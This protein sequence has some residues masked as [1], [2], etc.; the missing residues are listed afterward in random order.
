M[1][2]AYISATQF[3]VE[4]DLTAEFLPGRRIKADCGGD[5]YKYS[6]VTSRSYSNPYTTVTIAEGELTSNLIDVLYGI[7]N[8]G[9]EGSFP[10][11]TH[12]SSE[13]QGGVISFDDLADND[14][15]FLQLIDT[16]SSY[17]SN[18]VLETTGSGIVFSDKLDN[19]LQLTDTPTTYSG[20]EGKYII[21]TTSGLEFT[22]ISGGSGSSDVESFLDLNDTPTTY[23]GTEGQVATS[24]GSGIVFSN[25]DVTNVPLVTG[26]QGIK[27]EY[28]SDNEVYFNPG[29][30][31]LKDSNYDT[32]VLD[33]RISIQNTGLE[34]S[35]WYFIYVEEPGVGNLLS[36]ENFTFSSIVPTLDYVNQG[37][38]NGFKRCVG[39]VVTDSGSDIIRFEQN[40][41]DYWFVPK[42][43]DFSWALVSD[44]IDVACTSP[45]GDLIVHTRVRGRNDS[46]THTTFFIG[47]PGLNNQTELIYSN[48][49]SNIFATSYQSI[50]TD[51]SKQIRITANYYDI[52]FNLNT[53]GFQMPNYIYGTTNI[54]DN[55]F[56]TISGVESSFIADTLVKEWNFT[57][58]SGFDETFTWD[59]DED[60]ILYFETIN[61]NIPAG[62][63]ICMQFNNDITS[64]YG[65][66][67]LS[68]DGTDVNAFE[69]FAD[70][71]IIITNSVGI[72][73]SKMTMW[74]K[75]TGQKR[76]GIT[77]FATRRT[78]YSGK[79]HTGTVS[80]FWDNTTSKITSI[81]IW[82][83][84]N[85]V[86]GTFRLYKRGKVQLP[87]PSG[88][89]SGTSAVQSFLDLTDTP[90][91]YSGT[92]GQVATST[93]SGIAFTGL[94]GYVPWDFG[95]GT[96][97]GTGDIYCNDLH[98]ASGTVYIGDLKLSSTDGE[99]LLVNDD[100]IA[101]EAQSF[102]DLTDTSTTYSGSA[103]RYLTTAS[104]GIEFSDVLAPSFAAKGTQSI[105][106]EYKD[107]DEVYLN[108]GVVHIND[109]SVDGY[110]KISSRL[111]K[112][113]T[114]LSASVWYYIYIKKPVTGNEITVSEIEYSISV[115]EK[116]LTKLGYYHT[117]NTGWRCIG[118]FKSDATSDVE[119]FHS[120]NNLFIYSQSVGLYGAGITTTSF[121]DITTKVPFNE[122]SVVC[123]FDCDVGASSYPWV[124]WRPKGTSSTNWIFRPSVDGRDTVGLTVYI[125]IDKKFQIQFTEQPVQWINI[126][127]NGF[128]LPDELYTGPVSSIQEDV[129]H[130]FTE[131]TDTPTT[132]SGV[133]GKYLRT[134]ASGV[135]FVSLTNLTEVNVIGIQSIKVEYKDVDEISLGRGVVHIDNGLIEDYY[136][137][138]SRITKQLTSLLASTWYYIY[139]KQTISGNE[140]TINEIEYSTSVPEKSLTKLGYYHTTNTGWRCVGFILSNSSNNI[141]MFSNSA[142]KY[143][144]HPSIADK[145]WTLEANNDPVITLTVPFGNIETEAF[146]LARSN[147]DTN[148]DWFLYNSIVGT[149]NA[150]YVSAS[151]NT[152]FRYLSTITTYPCDSNKQISL[153]YSVSNEIGYKVYTRGFITP[154]FIYNGP[155]KIGGTSDV[156]IFTDLTDTPT[157]YSGTEGQVAT[158]TGSGIAFTGL[159]GYVPWDFGDGT[160]SGTGD[161]YCNDLHTASGTVYI[162]DLK[163]SSAGGNMLVDDEPMAFSKDNIILTSPN[164]S[165]FK[166][167]V[168]DSG[169]LST[170]AI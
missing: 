84:N 26:A 110:Y 17:E 155:G 16:P 45:F 169:N 108:Q 141:H 103:G 3:R 24:T 34:A 134:T 115:P 138:S 39:F 85:D 86:T 32:Y 147:D 71:H 7:V 102:L 13:G 125:D 133:E 46:A 104:N 161:I 75:N 109:A 54:V 9:S 74:L 168:D 40:G 79:W 53:A 30:V 61:A 131:L 36:A 149:D 52:K 69:T 14:I 77:Q 1:I 20:A 118:V 124:Y 146:Y 159:S 57:T 64:N 67:L 87:L 60:D 18:K 37:Y 148:G 91:T 114:S 78:D 70:T 150:T 137:I 151:H 154:D 2:A 43:Q 6:T 15:D 27:V 21:A 35:T 93:G 82:S 97:S 170:E 130:T 100:P 73:S 152:Y 128:Y 4:E 99:N 8:V 89:G 127:E 135:D 106:V 112:Q 33:Q 88:A 96:I 160:I 117:T 113:L 58:A 120:Q 59:G 94:S 140:I 129:V 48:Q 23:S 65:K 132:Y 105:K 90:T 156:Q 29:Y 111:T 28:K 158:S 122:I 123:T 95:D 22:T 11:H 66:A 157:T 121:F 153:K 164:G 62:S 55:D 116:S 139:I 50:L 81:K 38:Y 42:I 49:D 19:F 10:K 44:S 83:G 165:K 98:T 56:T 163:L 167:K 126:F 63:N 107:T 92:E 119:E 72:E 51:S 25:I 144:Y 5:G 145:E 47:T 41:S 162:G 101:A 166:I 142:N 136:K 68:Q 80:H 143:N 31:H 76:M 12:D